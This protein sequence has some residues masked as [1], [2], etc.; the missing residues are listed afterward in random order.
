MTSRRTIALPTYDGYTLRRGGSHYWRIER[1]GSASSVDALA[2]PQGY[3]DPFSVTDDFP[4][5][6]R[7]G[8]GTFSVSTGRSF[9]TAP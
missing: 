4:Y 7:T 9:T 3:L 6:P 1:H 2:G 8:D 5:G